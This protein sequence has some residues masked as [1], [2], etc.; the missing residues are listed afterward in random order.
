MLR[1]RESL[2]TGLPPDF[3]ANYVGRLLKS[4]G[5]AESYH[6]VFYRV[7]FSM[8]ALLRRNKLFGGLQVH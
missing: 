5:D 6:P 2:P 8:C 1:S 7:I 3:G 4:T